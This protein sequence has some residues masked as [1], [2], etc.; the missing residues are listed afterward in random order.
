[1]ACCAQQAKNEWCENLDP[2]IYV[3]TTDVT[4]QDTKGRHG[5]GIGAGLIN[6]VAWIPDLL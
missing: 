4:K 6:N 1:M 3:G 5:L 2:S